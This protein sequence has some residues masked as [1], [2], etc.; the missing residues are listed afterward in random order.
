MTTTK[1][2]PAIGEADASASASTSHPLQQTPSK[3]RFALFIATA[4]GLGYIPMAP[5]TWGSLAGVAIYC[6]DSMIDSSRR[7]SDLVLRYS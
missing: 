1:L 4:C 7:I 2:T 6:A 5:G 3:P